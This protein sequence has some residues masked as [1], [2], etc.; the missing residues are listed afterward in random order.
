MVLVDCTVYPANAIYVNNVLDLVKT[1]LNL[2]DTNCAHIQCPAM[3]SQTVVTALL[4]HRRLIEDSLVTGGCDVTQ[5][6][7]LQFDKSESRSNDSRKPVQF[8][9]AVT[10]NNHVANNWKA[11]SVFQYNRIGPVP[12]IRVADMV[13][14]DADVR[15]GAAARTEQIFGSFV[16]ASFKK[17][18]N[19]VVAFRRNRHVVPN[20]FCSL[21]IPKQ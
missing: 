14:F 6:V 17:F 13:G 1:V 4:K 19:L 2:S 8:C 12:L 5:Q 21:A 7:S 15:P 20:T 18:Q 16:S 11:C 9:L 3:Q 10:S